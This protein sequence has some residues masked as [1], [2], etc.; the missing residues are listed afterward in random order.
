MTFVVVNNKMQVEKFLKCYLCSGGHRL[1]ACKEF[2]KKSVEE[3]IDFVCSK[4]LCFKCL[5][6]KHISRECSLVM[7]IILLIILFI[8][9]EQILL[10]TKKRDFH[11]PS[12]AIGCRYS[13]ENGL[14]VKKR[15]TCS[16]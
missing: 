15:I 6:G 14:H 5:G 4:M 10:G 9:F 12:G 2:M 13:G 1:T 11:T 7:N 3:R 8:G 16:A